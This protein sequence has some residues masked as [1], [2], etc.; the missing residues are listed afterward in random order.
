LKVHNLRDSS[1]AAQQAAQTQAGVFSQNTRVSGTAKFY[2]SSNLA[3]IIVHGME[4]SEL[5][6]RNQLG[7]MKAKLAA[8]QAAGAAAAAPADGVEKAEKSQDAAADST[9]PNSPTSSTA[10]AA[11]EAVDEKPMVSVAETAAA[12][13]LEAMAKIEEEE[14][15]KAAKAA[16]G[17]N[18]VTKVSIQRHTYVSACKCCCRSSTSIQIHIA[19][20]CS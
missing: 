12:A 7:R 18:A 10:A 19:R 8:K 2:R 17:Q 5:Q 6:R 4:Y 9:E 20:A 16:K 15:R 3:S 11:A 1:S 14:A 13:A